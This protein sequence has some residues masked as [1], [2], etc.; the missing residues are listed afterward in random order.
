VPG[1]TAG[2][3]A[4]VGAILLTGVQAFFEV[5]PKLATMLQTANELAMAPHAFRSAAS[6]RSVMSGFSARR[7]VIQLRWVSSANSRY[8]PLASRRDCPFG[9]PASPAVL[10]HDS[11]DRKGGHPLSHLA[12]FRGILQ[13]DGYAGSAARTSAA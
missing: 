13:A 9:S 11:P 7:T 10:Y 5:R 6:A 12:G 1:P 8:H 4:C 3:I 2:P